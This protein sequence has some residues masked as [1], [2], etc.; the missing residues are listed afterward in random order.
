MKKF[1]LVFALLFGV[2]VFSQ[3]LTLQLFASNLN[4]PVNIKHAGDDRLFVAERGGFI[5]IV[6]AD[7]SLEPTPFLDIDGIVSNSG[8]ERGLLGLAFHPNYSSNGY[9]FVNYINNDG[10]TVISRFSRDSSNPNLA[11]DN[12]ELIILSY[13][14]PFSNHNGGDMHFGPD[15]FLYISS[16]D[17]GDGGDP[18]NNAQTLNNNLLGK[19]LRIDVN[20]SN[21]SN[22]YTIPADNPFVGNTNA[23]DEIWVY[24]LRNPWKFSFDRT[25]SELWIGD[26]GQGENEEI[27]LASSSE[28]GLNYGWRCYE[29]ND[30]FNTTGCPP[31]NTLTFPIAEYNHNNDGAF[32]CSITGGYRYRG[33]L[34]P[35]FEGIYFFADFCS[36]EIGTLI[37]NGTSW[38][39]EFNT[40]SGSWSA[41]GEDVNGELYV[42][43]LGSGDIYALLDAAALN[44]QDLDI[45]DVSI[46]PNPTNESLYINFTGRK[47]NTPSTISIFNLQGQLV[48]TNYIT[49]SKIEKIDVSGFAKGFYLLRIETEDGFNMT[50]KIVID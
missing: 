7:G 14:Q 8:G 23:S 22:P 42:A 5:K 41:F 50:Q 29:G 6:N 11:D 35:N 44:N 49:E 16:G 25:T 32:K 18:L 12:S 43:D 34:F 40:F 48:I 39:M 26:V 37:F 9:F 19:L 28:A 20:N 38:D 10:D 31:S 27:N 24:G 36:G 21:A 17:G 46:Y 1:A 2:H 30:P 33:L 4:N 45:N 13:D 47:N 15:G 3:D